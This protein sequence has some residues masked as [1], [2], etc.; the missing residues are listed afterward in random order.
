MSNIK[1]VNSKISNILNLF[2]SLFYDSPVNCFPYL[3]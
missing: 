3:F 2:N 1:I